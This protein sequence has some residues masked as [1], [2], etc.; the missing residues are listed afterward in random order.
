M[1]IVT[2]LSSTDRSA[3]RLIF[4]DRSPVFPG[5]EN[6]FNRH[7]IAAQKACYKLKRENSSVR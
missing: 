5:G 1:I 3:F 6:R 7:E 2:E 4:F